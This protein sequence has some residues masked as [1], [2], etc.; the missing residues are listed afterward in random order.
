MNLTF[1]VEMKFIL[2][3]MCLHFFISQ[4]IIDLMN[5]L[6]HRKYEAI[7]LTFKQVSC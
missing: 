4:K 1:F 3:V 2:I 6:D 7:Q 5:A